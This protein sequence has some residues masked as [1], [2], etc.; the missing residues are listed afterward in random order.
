[1]AIVIDLLSPACAGVDPE[2]F[3]LEGNSNSRAR[4]NQKQQA[5]AIC[6]RCPDLKGCD[7]NASSTPGLHGIWGGKEYDGAGYVSPIFV[8]NGREMNEVKE[9]ERWSSTM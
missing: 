1:M 6:K 7:T 5:I 4:A 3:F 9:V 8:C 2:L